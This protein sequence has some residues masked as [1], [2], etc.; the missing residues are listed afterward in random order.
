MNRKSI[1]LAFAALI[2]AVGGSFAVGHHYAH[3][4]R[5]Q[6]QLPLKE[7]MGHVMQRNAEQLWGWSAL[8]L[9]SKGEHYTKPASEQDWEN[10]ESDALTLQELTFALEGSG[11]VVNS[12]PRWAEHLQR[13]RAAAGRSAHAADTKDFAGLLK[14]GNDINEICVSCHKTFAPALESGPPPL[15][16]NL[17]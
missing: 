8:E 7:F 10:A 2:V 5:P 17:R 3:A 11:V 16:A 4:A 15:P 6:S 14:A 12:D 9:D 13:L 1:G